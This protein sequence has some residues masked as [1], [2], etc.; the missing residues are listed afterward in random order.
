M[1]RVFGHSAQALFQPILEDQRDRLRQALL[2]LLARTSLT[3]GA[4]NLPAPANELVLIF[5]DDGRKLVLQDSRL[6]ITPRSL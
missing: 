2:A 3:V 5:L 6:L 4:R 1:F